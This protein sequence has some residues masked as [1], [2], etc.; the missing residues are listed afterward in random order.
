MAST[1]ENEIVV[2]RKLLHEAME[3]QTAGNLAAA[4]PRYRDVIARGYR[5]ADVLPVLAGILAQ[6]GAL[7]EAIGHWDALLA[8]DP[9]HAVALHEKGLILGRLGQHDAAIASLQKACLADPGNPVSA[10]NLAVMLSNAGRKRE[11]LAEFQRALTLE[12]ENVHVRHQ[13]RRLGAEQVPFWH[14]PMMNDVRRNDA[15]EAAIKAAIE[16]RPNAL[17]LDIGTGSGLLSMMAAR[18]GAGSVV[19]CEVVPVIA[20]MARQIVAENGYANRIK[21]VAAPSTDL[22]V[23]AQLA[24]QADILVSEILS[25]DLLTENVLDTFE[26]A[27]A[28]LLKDDAI[29][30]PRAASAIGCLV[31]S[32]VLANY[33]FVNTVSGFDLSRFNAFAAQKLP[34]HGTMTDWRR[35]SADVELVR[36]DLTA[37]RHAS[38]LHLLSIP[39][40]SDGVATGIVQWMHVDLA[41]GVSFD[42]HPDGY[43]DGGWLQ[44]LHN[45]PAPIQ[46]RAGDTLDVA[47]GH[48]R[49]T[50]I[51]QP[52]EVISSARIAHVA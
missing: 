42:N 1:E 15:F 24:A 36:I 37:K 29:V 34:I 44:V 33:V 50:L 51:V 5:I 52:L 19:A 38:D 32:E 28:R 35:L 39:V 30:I 45:F 18:A 9:D 6:R 11:A 47:V 7:D 26:D 46:V 49:V 4:E 43:T 12:P 20:D 2:A 13:M 8:I 27:H 41:E 17:V 48:D 21:I 23:G 16:Q 40:L 10:N 14:I 3:L 31:E 25:S 22:D